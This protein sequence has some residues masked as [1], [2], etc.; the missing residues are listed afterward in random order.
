M[1]FACGGELSGA[2]FRWVGSYR[3][4]S[5][6]DMVAELC[7]PDFFRLERSYAAM[8]FVLFVA[9][10]AGILKYDLWQ[11]SV[12]PWHWIVV[13][14]G[15]GAPGWSFDLDKAS[16]LVYMQSLGSTNPRPGQLEPELEIV[17]STGPCMPN[18]NGDSPRSQ[19]WPCCNFGSGV[20][21]QSDRQC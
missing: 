16:Q 4:L 5:L 1:L 3:R 20:L 2:K 9:V 19:F 18:A 13:Y 8:L 14:I 11:S 21:R 10:S 15:P 7:L 12:W 17:Q 6:P